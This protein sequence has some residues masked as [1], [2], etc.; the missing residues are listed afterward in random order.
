VI[1]Q[2]EGGNEMNNSFV[3]VKRYLV[4]AVAA[5]LVVTALVLV[6]V[7]P[8]RAKFWQV[9]PPTSLEVNTDKLHHQP[10]NARYS[11]R[12]KTICFVRDH[13]IHLFELSTGRTKKLFAG[14]GCNISPGGDA[15]AVTIDRDE[16]KKIGYPTNIKIVD[17]TTQDTKDLDF[18]SISN[19]SNPQWSP[20]G[21]KLAFELAIDHQIHVVVLNSSTGEWQDVTRDLDFLDPRGNVKTEGVSLDSWGPE[22]NSVICQ[23]MSLIYEIKIDGTVVQKIPIGTVADPRDV[24]VLGNMKFSYSPDRKLMA[25]F[26]SSELKTDEVNLAIYILDFEIKKLSKI[27]LDTIDASSPIWLPSGNQ[28]MFQRLQKRKDARAVWDICVIS[29]E[30]RNVTTIVKNSSAASYSFD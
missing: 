25:F 1:F 15:I 20:D 8:N 22:G 11:D 9:P 23:D 29:I 12:V 13:F 4:G 27:T 7:V 24:Q 30:N 26:S 21:S 3:S 6:F 14:E 28:I 5:V 2:K 10:V 16:P 17:L 19:K 18:I